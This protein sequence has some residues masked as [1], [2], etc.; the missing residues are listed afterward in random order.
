MAKGFSFLSVYRLYLFHS[1]WLHLYKSACFESYFVNYFICYFAH[2][3]GLS[4]D[5][6]GFNLYH[7]TKLQRLYVY[8]L[9]KWLRGKVRLV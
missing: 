5:C 9:D 2:L 3:L 6:P 1:Q 7:G 8:K 4:V